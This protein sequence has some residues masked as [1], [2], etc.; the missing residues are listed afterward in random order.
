MALSNGTSL[1]VAGSKTGTVPAWGLSQV[2]AVLTATV[3]WLANSWD[4]PPLTL[5]TAPSLLQSCSN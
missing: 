1:R 2:F 3:S 4:S 5:G